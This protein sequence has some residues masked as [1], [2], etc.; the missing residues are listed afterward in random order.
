MNLSYSCTVTFV[1]KNKRFSFF[2]FFFR[3]VQ[4]LSSIYIPYMNLSEIIFFQEKWKKAERIVVPKYSTF[5]LQHHFQISFH[6]S[7]RP[8]LPRFSR[9]I[10]RSIHL[11]H[12]G[13]EIPFLRATITLLKCS[14]LLPIHPSTYLKLI[15]IEINRRSKTI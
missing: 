3:L 8:Y 12:I 9:V 7:L 5:H 15:E 4:C 13:R 10:K 6:S 11:I 14:Q 1:E 2:P